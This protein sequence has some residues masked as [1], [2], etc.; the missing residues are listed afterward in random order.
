MLLVCGM[1]QLAA[2]LIH[3]V[4]WAI[5]LLRLPVFHV[6]EILVHFVLKLSQLAKSVLYFGNGGD[7]SALKRIDT[8]VVIGK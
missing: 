6:N 8:N 5:W 4:I 3:L 1:L 7:L 2:A